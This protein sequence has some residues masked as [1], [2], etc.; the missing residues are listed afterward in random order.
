ML[1][2][3]EF[4]SLK[5]WKEYVDTFMDN[6]VVEVGNDAVRA[7]TPKGRIL[8]QWGK[9]EGAYYGALKERRSI[10]RLTA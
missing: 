7:V 3:E 9:F 6:A 5:E 2:V 8:G 4:Y 10:H 1:R